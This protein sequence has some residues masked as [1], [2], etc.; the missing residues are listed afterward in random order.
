MVAKKTTNS[1]AEPTETV[2][3]AGSLDRGLEEAERILA[4]DKADIVIDFKN[5]TFITVEGLEWLEELLLRAESKKHD[6]TFTN[7]T[8]TV[9]KVFKVCHTDS[10][11][12]ACGAPSTAS[13]SEC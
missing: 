8:P 4:A 12:K 5:C 7:I 1:K 11:L 10:I 3:V 9:Y 6:V 2:I 13:G